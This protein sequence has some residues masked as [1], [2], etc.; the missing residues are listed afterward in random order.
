MAILAGLIKLDL[1]PVKSSQAL[2]FLALLATFFFVERT[3]RALSYYTDRD[4][5][6]L[7]GIND[8]TIAHTHIP[9]FGKGLAGH[10][11]YNLDYVFDEVRPEII[12]PSDNEG[13]PRTTDELR[14]FFSAPSPIQARNAYLN[15]LRLWNQ[16]VVRSLNIDGYWFNFFQRRDTVDDLQ[17]PELR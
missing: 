8:V 11:K 15:D 16:Y 13:V 5:L 1:D 6:D 4:M 17:A 9:G 12:V 3:W 7:R 10:E 14:E 2:G